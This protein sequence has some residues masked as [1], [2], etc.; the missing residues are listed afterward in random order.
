MKKYTKIKAL[1]TTVTVAG[2]T[3]LSQTVAFAEGGSKLLPGADGLKDDI[4]SLLGT[5]FIIFLAWGAFKNY[6]SQAYGKM[7]ALIGGGV[8]VAWIVY[9]PD[10]FIGFIKRILEF[11]TQV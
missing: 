1:L 11:F 7:A 8:L 2:S 10:N 4:L 6:V 3:I 9:F 5:V